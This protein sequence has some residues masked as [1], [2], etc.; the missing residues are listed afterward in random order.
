MS[1]EHFALN[2]CRH[3]VDIVNK[4]AVIIER[5]DTCAINNITETDKML[6]L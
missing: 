5:S 1:Q 4:L 3:F 2:T 6:T